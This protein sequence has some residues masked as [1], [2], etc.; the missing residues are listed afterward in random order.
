MQAGKLWVLPFGR[1]NASWWGRTKGRQE[2]S[3]YS[4]KRPLCTL[5]EKQLRSSPSLLR[6]SPCT[7]YWNSLASSLAVLFAD[8]FPFH[9][10]AL[11]TS[12][13]LFFFS[14]LPLCWGFFTILSVPLTVS[15]AS[16]IQAFLIQTQGRSLSR[17][18]AREHSSFLLAT[19]EIKQ[20][21]AMTSSLWYCFLKGRMSISLLPEKIQES[22]KKGGRKTQKYTQLGWRGK[23]PLDAFNLP[24]KKRTPAV[25]CSICYALR[26][27]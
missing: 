11:F 26:L 12:I 5:Q 18:W 10:S 2:E 7:P 8:T 21:A 25:F 9:V 27:Q 22:K 16:T 19:N 24:K 4:S 14:L 17:V 1:D 20:A 23:H 15:L 6:F 3:T 13:F